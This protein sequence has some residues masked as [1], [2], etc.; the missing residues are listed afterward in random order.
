MS[1]RVQIRVQRKPLHISP[2]FSYWTLFAELG[3]VITLLEKHDQQLTLASAFAP[4]FL[5]S[6]DL[7]NSLNI[8]YYYISREFKRM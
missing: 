7:R 4:E 6:R 2:T 1:E 8:K 3:R 5:D